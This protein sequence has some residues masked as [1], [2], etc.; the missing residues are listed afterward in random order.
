MTPFALAL[1]GVTSLAPGAAPQPDPAAVLKQVVQAY[2]RLKT[3]QAKVQLLTQVSISGAG[4]AL[5]ESRATLALDRGKPPRGALRSVH[6]MS[7]CDG[8]RFLRYQAHAKVYTIESA[9]D[10]LPG[11]LFRLP[12]GRQVTQGQLTSLL[13]LAGLSRKFS[14][15]RMGT[16]RVVADGGPK[17]GPLLHLQAKASSASTDFWIDRQTHLIRRHRQTYTGRK[18][19]S[20]GL[21]ILWAEEAHTD[22]RANQ[23]IPDEVFAVAIPP[24]ASTCERLPPLPHLRTLVREQRKASTT[25]KR[26]APTR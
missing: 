15:R 16:V 7:V 20:K 26:P 17:A 25:Q 2:D 24:G 4:K 11:Y 18:P 6:G 3:Y 1:A 10:L 21:T 19:S 9:P 8:Q 13:L 23:P 22:V 12:Y 14:P 5:Y